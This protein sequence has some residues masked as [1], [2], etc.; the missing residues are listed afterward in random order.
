MTKAV[1]PMTDLS[2]LI[3]RVEAAG[4]PDRELDVL[5]ELAAGA[6]AAAIQ[7]LIDGSAHN[8]IDA[9]ARAADREGGLMFFRVPRF[10]A[11]LDAAMTLVPRGWIVETRR[12]YNSEGEYVAAVWLTD[13]FTVGRGCDPDEKVTVSARIVEQSQGVDPTPAAICAAAMR[14]RGEAT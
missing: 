4:V 6:N 5:I 2:T 8:T 13:S 11:S 9:I 14:A 3:G 10:T 7:K 1:T 12:Y